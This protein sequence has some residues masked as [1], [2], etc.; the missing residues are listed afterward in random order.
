MSH[1]AHFFC[2]FKFIF[3]MKT[4]LK[5]SEISLKNNRKIRIFFIFLVLTSI[6]WLLIELS[7]TYTSTAV[8]KIDY[9]NL[10]TDK[11]LQNKPVTEVEIAIKSTGFTLLKY[12]TKKHVVRFNLKNLSRNKS[13]YYFLPNTQLTTINKQLVG[14]TE[15]VRV[16]RDT[17]FMELGANISKKIPVTPTFDIKYKL[18]YNLTENLKI[19]PDSVIITG[20][21][22]F[23][24]SV[25]DI[26]TTALKLNDVYKSIDVNLT[27]KTPENKNIVLSQKSVKIVG[28]VDK[29]TEGA[30]VI[31]VNVIN[32]PNNITIRTFPEEVEVVYQAG[33]SNFS[34]INQ[35]SFQIVY[36]FK[37]YEN[38]TLINYLTPVIE[39]KSDYISSLKINPPQVE[40]LIQ[41]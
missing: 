14:N 24:D 18:G 21:E 4:A 5:S 11:L 26:K 35:N 16:L 23:V 13:L 41:K 27:L 22:K 28:E 10:P 20:P 36:D 15:V 12:K 29:F 32:T 25:K 31:P 30:F 38:D 17:I 19:I 34:K 40:F 2:I 37:Q 6:I 1:V 7:K 8:F 9:N 3:E 39:Q 33:L